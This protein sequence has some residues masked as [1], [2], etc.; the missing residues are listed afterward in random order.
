LT[1]LADV[2]SE[3]EGTSDDAPPSV[4]KIR[5]AA[6]QS[7]AAHGTAATTLRAVA[8]SAGVS[9]GLV[10]HHFATKAGLIKAVDDYV[11][12]A[13]IAPMAQPISERA[14]DSITEVGNRVIDLVAANP[15]IA[16]YL[17]RAVV[18]GSQ[19]GARIFDSLLEVG[20]A[21][22]ELR[23]ERGETRPDIDV[24]WAAINSLVL[25][26]GA[27]SLRSH[28]DRHLP[29]PFISPAQLQRWQ[30]SVSSLLRDGLFRP[31]G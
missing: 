27:I 21:R 8:A 30:L 31:L 13:V 9:L 26:L 12:D 6:L 5:A 22:W 4:A 28:I 2:D 1:T 20:I 25:A 16:A 23:A 14:G 10:Q 18:D 24:M 3:A 7:F 11:V 17:G 15:A 19:L 29:E